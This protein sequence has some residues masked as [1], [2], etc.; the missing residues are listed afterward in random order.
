MLALP[1]ALLAALLATLAVP[2][3][4]VASSASIATLALLVIRLGQF[5]TAVARTVAQ[6]VAAAGARRR[7]RPGTLPSTFGRTL[8]FDHAF[9]KLVVCLRN[10]RSSQAVDILTPND[11]LINGRAV[12]C[13]RLLGLQKSRAQLLR[14]SYRFLHLA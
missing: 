12:H 13:L 4:F 9:Q 2:V 11:T 3:A 1:A 8:L 10:F 6:G 14:S 5:V 7:G